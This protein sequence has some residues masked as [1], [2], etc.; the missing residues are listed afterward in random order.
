L[1]GLL[2]EAGAAISMEVRQGQAYLGSGAL[3]A[4][5]IP[6]VVVSVAV[7]GRG[8]TVLA[9]SLRMDEACVFGRIEGERVLLDMRTVTDDEV[10]VIAQALLR[11]VSAA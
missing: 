1:A 4:E 9:R 5:A 7:E 11:I 6:S 10:P 2:L 8:A 3:P